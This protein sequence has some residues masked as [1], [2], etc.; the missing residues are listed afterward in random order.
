MNIKLWKVFHYF[1]IYENVL[2]IT[3]SSHKFSINRLILIVNAVFPILIFFKVMSVILSPSGMSEFLRP[4]IA[5]LKNVSSLFTKI[6]FFFPSM[7]ALSLFFIIILLF[8]QTEILHF[9]KVFKRT[10]KIMKLDLQSESFQSLE[11]WSFYIFI[12]SPCSTIITTLINNIYIGNGTIKS[13]IILEM[14][15]WSAYTT[16]YFIFMY[17]MSMKFMAVSLQSLEDQLIKKADHK[18]LFDILL[19][20]N[21]IGAL[22]EELHVKF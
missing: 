16:E 8:F 11:N 15:S 22:I 10:I 13:L 3:N 19:K 20:V 7:A 17:N 12:L 2:S 4:E 14:L 9:A 18:K 1:L 6:V 21:A 5:N